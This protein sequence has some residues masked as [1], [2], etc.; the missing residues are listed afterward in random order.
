M[1]LFFQPTSESSQPV[2]GINLDEAVV[3]EAIAKESEKILPK[4]SEETQEAVLPPPLPT[5]NAT[6]GPKT[7]SL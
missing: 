7:K 5:R 3:N 6:D 4:I 2:S 1:L